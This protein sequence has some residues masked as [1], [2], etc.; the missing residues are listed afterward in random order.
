MSFHVFVTGATGFVGTAVVQELLQAGH[1]VTGLA[2]SDAAAQQLTTAGAS[3]PPRRRRR[4]R[5][6]PHHDFAAYEA[7]CEAD[8]KIIRA[9]GDALLG[10][11]KLLIVTSATPTIVSGSHRQ[12]ET[13]TTQDSHNPRKVAEAAVDAVAATGVRVVVVRL[14]PSVHGDGDRAFVPLLIGIAREKGVSAYIGNGANRWPA[15]HRL[16]AAVLFRLVLEKA[17]TSGA[18]HAVADQGVTLRELAAV[19]G[20]RLNVPVVSK[21]PLEAT[22]HFGWFN[23][24]AG[25]DNPIASAWTQET[26]GWKP[27]QKSLL[28]DLD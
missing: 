6:H 28:E 2:R 13:A 17:T 8:A 27:T 12:D 22:D 19:I 1:H 7:T 9:L 5:D 20:K 18:A 10:T 25:L 24:F 21:D 4:R 15:V 26:Y 16:D 11:S 23:Y 14:P 3:S